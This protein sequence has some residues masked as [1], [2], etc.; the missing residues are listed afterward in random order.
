MGAVVIYTIAKNA[1]G[2]GGK[3]APKTK[4]G[5]VVYAREVFRGMN[6][7]ERKDVPCARARG[8]PCDFA[9]NKFIRDRLI[10]RPQV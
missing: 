9:G 8:Y 7:R 6:Q 1:R 5:I 2:N 10:Y 4:K 3:R